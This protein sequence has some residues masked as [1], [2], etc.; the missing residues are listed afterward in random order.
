MRVERSLVLKAEPYGRSPERLGYA[1]GFKPKTVRTRLGQLELQVRQVRGGVAF[2]RSSL[3]RGLRSERALKLAV[4]EMCVQGV[5]TRK[6]SAVLEQLCGSDITSTQVSRAAQEMNAE[7]EAWRQRPLGPCPYLIL[8]ARY[9][10]VRLAG[11]V[12]SCA[13]A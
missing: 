1:K 3:D 8:D 10:K 12:R 9:E 2:Y 6:M 4:A 5:S 13:A 11:A 7:L